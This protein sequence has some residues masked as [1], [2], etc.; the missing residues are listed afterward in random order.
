MLSCAEPITAEGFSHITMQRI[1]TLC[2]PWCSCW[3][4]RVVTQQAD[5]SKNSKAWV[6]SQ[7]TDTSKNK[8][9]AVSQHV[10]TNKSPGL[11]VLAG[12]SLL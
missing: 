6:V 5:T 7:Q 9:W 2:S 1:T 11:V 4:Q 8:A 12:V 3:C 10:D